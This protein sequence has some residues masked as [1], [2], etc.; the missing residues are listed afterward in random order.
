MS[1]I[2]K[3][4]KKKLI[5]YPIEQEVYERLIALIYEYDG[6]LSLASTIGII[7]LLKDKIKSDHED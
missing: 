4:G 1:D 5:D 3:F 7:D 6:D 2:R